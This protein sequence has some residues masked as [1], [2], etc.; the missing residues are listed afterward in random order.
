MK[1][2]RLLVRVAL[3]FVAVAAIGGATM[4]LVKA[5]NPQ[6][7]P[8]GDAYSLIGLLDTQ[9]IELTVSNFSVASRAFPPGPCDG[10]LTFYDPAGNVVKTETFHITEGRSALLSFTPSATT[11][12]SVDQAPEGARRTY[13]RGA[14]SFRKA[15]GDQVGRSTT[16]SCVSGLSVVG[17][18]GET[19]LFTNPGVAHLTPQNHNETLVL[20]TDR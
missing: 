10:A 14:V 15:G 13:L 12:G 19:S 20:D 3:T 7:D 9:S 6:P 18:T 2:A 5:F 4:T 1:S 8:P 11:V 16:D 17:A